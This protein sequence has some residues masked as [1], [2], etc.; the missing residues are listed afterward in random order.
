M[1]EGLEPGRSV[2]M[3]PDRYIPMPPLGGKGVITDERKTGYE[4]PN[5]RKGEGG[6]LYFGEKAVWGFDDDV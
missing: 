6:S 5:P 1:P 2:G 4:I 3:R